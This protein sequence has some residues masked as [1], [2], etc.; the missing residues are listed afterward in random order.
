MHS[1]MYVRAATV[2]QYVQ[3]T[4]RLSYSFLI[5]TS[6]MN[7]LDQ[8]WLSVPCISLRALLEIQVLEIVNWV[9]LVSR[10]APS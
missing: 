9:S 2:S 6:R 8:Q 5:E 4:L 1:L 10:R 7:L 3:E